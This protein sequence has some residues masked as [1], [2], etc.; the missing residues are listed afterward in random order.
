MHESRTDQFSH[1]MFA[2]RYDFEYRI[3]ATRDEFVMRVARAPLP[4]RVIFTDAG[5]LPHNMGG[6]QFNI[7]VERGMAPMDAIISHSPLSQQVFSISIT[8]AKTVIKLYSIW[9]LYIVA[10][11]F[12]PQLRVLAN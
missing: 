7:M 10:D 2:I 12:I 9:R 6:W 3:Y 5:V 4:V 1:D 11:L 8:K